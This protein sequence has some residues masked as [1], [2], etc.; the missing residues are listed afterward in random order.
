MQSFQELA[1]AS[2]WLRDGIGYTV[3]YP[4]LDPPLRGFN[5]PLGHNKSQ[6][7]HGSLLSSP[8]PGKSK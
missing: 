4:L 2:Y 7:M 6:Y 3:K 5:F 1:L 8:I